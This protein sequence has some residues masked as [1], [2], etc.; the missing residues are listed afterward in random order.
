MSFTYDFTNY[1]QLSTVRLLV[2]DTNPAQPIFQDDEI[3]AA[4]QI[5]SSGNVGYPGVIIG[6][7]GY[8]PAVPVQQVI[9]YRRAA[10]LLLRALGSSKARNLI[11]SVLDVKMDGPA[12][13]AAL[14]KIADSYIEDEANA[15]YF[16][17]SEMVQDSF[18]MR[19]R[20]W[21]MLYRTNNT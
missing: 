15:G 20:L 19:E 21:K 12:A 5:E 13:S 3:N 17:I 14:S 2:F 18:S 4:M 11:E 9:S 6:L 10:A 16:A 7:T 8:A 1:P